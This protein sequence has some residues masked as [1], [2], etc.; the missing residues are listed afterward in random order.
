MIRKLLCCLIGHDYKFGKPMSSPKMWCARCDKDFT[1]EFENELE[2]V[3]KECEE[4][5]KRYRINF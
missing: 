1:K 3:E 2:I 4:R 5:N